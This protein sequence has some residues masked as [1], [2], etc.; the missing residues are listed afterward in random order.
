[1]AVTESAPRERRSVAIAALTE[2]VQRGTAPDAALARVREAL[3]HGPDALATVGS[4]RDEGR[5]GTGAA[6]GGEAGGRG[7]A[8]GPPANVPAPG[9]TSQPRKPSTSGTPA[10]PG[11][12][13]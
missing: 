4:D 13:R 10:N 6:R 12:G 11:R 1:K 8:A 9:G 2:L 7:A 3:K 5:G